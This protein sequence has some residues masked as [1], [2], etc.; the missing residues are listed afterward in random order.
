M[1][2]ESAMALSLGG[3]TF[4]L[5][6]IWGG[7]LIQV[8]RR[9]GIGKKIRIE[10]P[11]RHITKLGTPTMGGWLIVISVLTVTIV[12]NLVSLL[13]DLQVLGR[14]VL[15]PTLVMLSYAILGAV[16]DWLGVKGVRRGEGLPVWRMRGFAHPRNVAV[17]E[18]GPR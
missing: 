12:L 3:I 4:L 2:G 5:A 18:G 16:D 15:L 1:T 17:R 7:P 6:V 11:E 9:L 10:G 8:L 14:S 13:T